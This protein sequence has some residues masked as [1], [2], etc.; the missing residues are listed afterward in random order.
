MN[1]GIFQELN[2]NR[3]W[4][5]FPEHEIQNE[6]EFCEEKPVEIL[7][8]LQKHSTAMESHLLY[9]TVFSSF[10]SSGLEI[11]KEK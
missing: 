2:R 7:A 6:I 11:C 3:N 9:L 10:G 4:K 1:C 5:F 8:G